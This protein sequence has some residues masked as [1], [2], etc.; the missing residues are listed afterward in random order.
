[1]PLTPRRESHV[2]SQPGFTVP[3]PG[4]GRSFP[5]PCSLD[6]LLTKVSPLKGI[7]VLEWDLP[8]PRTEYSGISR[9]NSVPRGDGCSYMVLCSTTTCRQANP[10]RNGTTVHPTCTYPGQLYAGAS[11]SVG[12]PSFPPPVAS[13]IPRCP[14]QQ[15]W[16]HSTLLWASARTQIGILK[17]QRL[18]RT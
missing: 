10:I 2:R 8:M 5:G 1:M 13:T 15:R 17:S 7:S 14:W 18:R 16:I 11:R 3:Y 12:F 4:A 9:K 6:K